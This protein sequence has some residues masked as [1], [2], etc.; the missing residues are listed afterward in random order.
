MSNF[1][2]ETIEAVWRKGKTDSKNDPNQF[3]K[4]VCGRWM[5]RSDYGKRDRKYGWEID[6]IKPVSKGGSDHISNLQPL[7][8]ESNLEKGDS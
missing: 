1:T 8:W 2:E 5:K 7:H 3:R 6:H 4:D